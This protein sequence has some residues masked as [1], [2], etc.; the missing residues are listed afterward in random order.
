MATNARVM[1]AALA[2]ALAVQV[3]AAR[4]PVYVMLQLDVVNNSNELNDPD[5]LKSQLQQ[6]KSG[7]VE[8]VMGDVW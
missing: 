2:C 5:G 4:I 1:L 8:G 3:V 7:G 6:L